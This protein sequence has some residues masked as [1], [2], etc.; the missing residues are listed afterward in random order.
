MMTRY[1]FILHGEASYEEPRGTVFTSDEGAVAHAARI[2]R[3]LK[4]GHR[5]DSAGWVIEIVDGTR[6]VE[7]ID[8]AT[9][10]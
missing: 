3:E 8:F 6:A 9:V 7:R 1:H 5:S 4:A 10:Q 2:A